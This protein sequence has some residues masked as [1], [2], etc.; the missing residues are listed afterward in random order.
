MRYLLIIAV[1]FFCVFNTDAQSKKEQIK[2]LNE[3]LTILRNYLN[4]EKKM[5]LEKSNKISELS[6]I[7]SNL[8]NNNSKL[9]SNISNLNN[10]LQTNNSNLISKQEELANLKYL[11]KQKSDSLVLV[12]IEL[13]KL[14][15]LSTNN[16]NTS[17]Q[18]T[19]TNPT[20]ANTTTN[21]QNSTN[22]ITQTGNYKSVKIGTQTWMVENL[23]VSTFRNGDPIPEAKT[24]EEWEKAGKNKQPAWCYYENDPKNGA[25]YGKLYNWYAVS[26]PRGLAPVGWH[27]PTD[28]EWTLLSDFL[29]YDNGKKMKSTSGWDSWQE[30]LTC[31]NCINWNDTYRS[32]KRGCDVCQDTKLNGKKTHS[33]NG[34]N[35]SGFSG[36]PGGGRSILGYFS[37]LGENGEWWSMTVNDAYIT[38]AYAFSR[39][40]GS[41]FN[42]YNTL[43][44]NKEQGL[45]VRC[46]KD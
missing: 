37:N 17:N 14:K 4:A 13:E 21:S 36:L 31:Q 19:Q 32:N 8:E 2:Q 15:S 40:L 30:K 42:L 45:S 24:N 3:Q 22:S 11:L 16:T 28:A 39:H 1:V 35:S 20:N 34:S 27:V 25:K 33:G 6:T 18:N 29:G 7:I 38:R 23:N 46:L 9:S 44:D 43:G 5:N 41:R 10:E 26:D 12:N